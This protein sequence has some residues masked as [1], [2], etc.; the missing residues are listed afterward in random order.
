MKQIRIQ[1]DNDSYNDLKTK[2]K[3]L[4]MSLEHYAGLKL[5]GYEITRTK[6]E[7]IVDSAQ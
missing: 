6:S 2:A 1:V 5:S 7:E 4:R 3:E